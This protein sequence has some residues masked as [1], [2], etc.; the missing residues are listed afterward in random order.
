MFRISLL[1]I[2]TL[3]IPFSDYNSIQVNATTSYLISQ[4]TNQQSRSITTKSLGVGG[5]KLSM[6]EAQVRKILGR[7]VKVENTFMPAIG[8][9]RT[10]K[11]TGITV[12]LAED[13]KPGK[14]TVYQIK[15][16]SSKYATVDGIKVG[17]NQSKVVRIYGNP[18][19]IQNG[20]LTNLSYGMDEPSPA[21]LNFSLRNNKVTEILCFYLMN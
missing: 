13:V 4:N 5:I 15:V 20:R 8:N 9:V 18:A 3:I 10:L 6:S 19:T 2:A 16:T 17:D 11:Y 14:F 1:A 7:P 12:D 21:G